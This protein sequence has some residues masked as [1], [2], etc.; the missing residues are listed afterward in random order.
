MSNERGTTSIWLAKEKYKSFALTCKRFNFQISEILEAFMDEF[1]A[2]YP[3]EDPD[4]MKFI[5]APIFIPRK[6]LT[7][8]V[9][10]DFQKGLL[11]WLPIYLCSK[12]GARR[13]ITTEGMNFLEKEGRLACCLKCG[14]DME[15]EEAPKQCP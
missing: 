2:R 8:H 6:K 11:K 7:P 13:H 10:E 15:V 4:E 3:L 14:A 9:R 12:C 1:M 5:Q